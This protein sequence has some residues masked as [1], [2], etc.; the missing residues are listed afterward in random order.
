MCE[1]TLNATLDWLIATAAKVA[2]TDSSSS[3]SSNQQ[4][5]LL[6]RDELHK[7]LG[8]AY[9]ERLCDEFE[10]ELKSIGSDMAAFYNNL[11]GFHDLLIDQSK[12]G[13]RFA[14]SSVS[15]VGYVPLFKCETSADT[16]VLHIYSVQ[17]E[18]TSFVRHFYS[19]LIES[20]TRRLWSLGSARVSPID[21]DEFDSL[22]LGK[23]ALSSEHFL[24]YR[25]ELDDAT[26]ASALA[27]LSCGGGGGATTELRSLDDSREASALCVGVD[28]FK[29]IFPFTI[30]ID[31]SMCIR[32]LGEGLIHQLSH[33]VKDQHADD[34][35]F[36]SFF[37][38][39][40]PK[41]NAYTFQS[42]LLNSN[43][44][45][46][47]R[48]RCELMCENSETASN[49]DAVV[50][51]HQQVKELILKG[52]VVHVPESDCLLFIGSPFLQ[53]LD[54]LTR[55]GLFMSDIPIH[56]ATRDIILIHEQTKAQVSSVFC[57]VCSFSSVGLIMI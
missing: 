42:M 27:P 37:E 38:I 16:S 28:D 21:N 26:L 12:F 22:Q 10:N 4:R 46:L 13:A 50:Q 31:R 53:H 57:F 18:L 7:R 35:H 2:H 14:Y 32:E 5:T 44:S 30:I 25:V 52:S 51:Q 3:S 24:G 36:D 9:F 39:I 6:T 20:S 48:T 23:T 56:D 8:I 33:L 54:D 15:L 11:N 29:A 1:E 55:C 34:L 47:I 17:H 45:F 40:K 43:M 49:T 19:G 41:L